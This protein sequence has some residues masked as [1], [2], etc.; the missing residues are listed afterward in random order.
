M[1]VAL[2]LTLEYL[3]HSVIQVHIAI[4]QVDSPTLIILYV[5]GPQ[6]YMVYY[7]GRFHGMD[8]TIGE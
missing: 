1:E 2:R 4:A 6:G 3:A 7:T 8:Q 5:N